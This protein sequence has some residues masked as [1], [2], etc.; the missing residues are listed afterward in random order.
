MDINFKDLVKEQIVFILMPIILLALLIG[1]IVYFGHTSYTGI[2]S[3]NK[4]S[5]EVTALQDKKADLEIKVQ[6]QKMEDLKPDK[7]KIF[8]LEGLQFSTDASFAPLFDDMLTIAKGSN[9]KIRSINYNYAPSEDPIF[10]AKLPGFNVCELNATLVG[11]YN[12]LRTFLKS[13]LAKEYLVNIAEL[14]IVSWQRD[15]RVLIANTK[16]RFYTKTK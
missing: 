11:N 2:D 13:L 12:E 14:E 10:S 4:K 9:V 15:K 7:K 3:Y 1:G 8:E 16:L 6:V 5:K